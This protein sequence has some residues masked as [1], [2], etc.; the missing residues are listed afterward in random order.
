MNVVESR[1][2]LGGAGL[3]TSLRNLFS[4]G[5]TVADSLTP[6]NYS[7]NVQEPATL[8]LEKKDTAEFNFDDGLTIS[9]EESQP[10]HVHFWCMSTDN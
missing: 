5:W 10:K 1:D 2:L 6:T 4:Q 3:F 8:V 9:L 7:L